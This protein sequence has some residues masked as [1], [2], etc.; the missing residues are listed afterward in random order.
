MMMSAYIKPRK[1]LPDESLQY[2]LCRSLEEFIEFEHATKNFSSM[3][4][5][6]TLLAYLERNDDE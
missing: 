4:F 5:H 6:E 3:V 2:C 1:K